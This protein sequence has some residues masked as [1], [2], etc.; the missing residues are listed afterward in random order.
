MDQYGFPKEAY[1]KQD[2]KF[3]IRELREDFPILI[4][5]TKDA[6]KESGIIF[7]AVNN[8]PIDTVANTKQDCV[9]IEVWSPNDTFNDL[10]LLIANAKRYAPKKQVILSA[11]LHPF[12]YHENKDECQN[13]AILT[14]ASI[15]SSGGFHL[16]LGE[17]NSFLTCA[18]YPD[19]YVNKNK[20]FLMKLRSY[21]DFIV[22]YEQ[23][24]FDINIIDDTR[25]YTGGINDDYIFSGADFS[26]VAEKNKVWTQ[27]KHIDG[28][29]I[30]HLVNFTN[31]NNMNWN[32][33]KEKL[34]DMLEDITIEANVIEEVESISIASPD[35]NNGESIKIKFSFITREN[36]NKVIKFKVPKLYV[37]DMIYIK[38]K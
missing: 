34:P 30:I 1:A 33:P 16:V 22:A 12:K 2:D 24:L 10:N 29:K 9:Y 38:L 8:W 11:Y 36:G 26:V 5:E 18:Y 31:V 27:V 28:Y 32:E 19:Y 17:G 15:F 20:S 4:N 3:V 6:L 14:M 25:F 7:N 21:Y 35:I 13:T 37:W 23:L